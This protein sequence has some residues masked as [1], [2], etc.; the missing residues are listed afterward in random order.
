MIATQADE[1]SFGPDLDGGNVR[2]L[3]YEAAAGERDVDRPVHQGRH[4]IG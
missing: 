3:G 4:Q 2:V 1:K